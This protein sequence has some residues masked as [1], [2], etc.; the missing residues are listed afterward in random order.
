MSF[1]RLSNGGSQNLTLKLTLAF[2]KMTFFSFGFC[3]TC[4]GLY[5]KMLKENALKCCF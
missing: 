3:F 4:D 2:L 1:S 5:V